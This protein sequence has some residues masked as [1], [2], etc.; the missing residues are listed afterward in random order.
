MNHDFHTF[1][2]EPGFE[3]GFGKTEF[4]ED[5]RIRIEIYRVWQLLG[6]VVERGFRQ[7]A[8]KNLYFWVYDVF[9]ESVSRLCKMTG[10]A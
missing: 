1:S 3:E 5:E 7:Y 9:R 10:Q 2:R 4:N 6:M 8:D